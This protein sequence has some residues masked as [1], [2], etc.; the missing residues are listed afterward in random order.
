MGWLTAD[1][2]TY[3]ILFA[4]ADGVFTFLP[5]MLA[6]TAAKSSKPTSF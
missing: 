6:L 4:A 5:V 1:S 3:Q 2:G